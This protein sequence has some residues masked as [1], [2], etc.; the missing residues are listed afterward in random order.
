LWLHSLK[1]AQLLRSA[2]CLH[3]NQSRSYL[4]HLVYY[5][6]L[7]I[8]LYH[9]YHIIYYIILYIINPLSCDLR[10]FFYIIIFFQ[11]KSTYLL[12][13]RSE[14]GSQQAVSEGSSGNTC[15]LMTLF[16]LIHVF[17]RYPFYTHR[18]SGL[19]RKSLM[20]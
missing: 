3:T 19:T 16:R 6:V 4:N 15:S 12:F 10:C 18:L 2:A 14:A 17:G 8:I 9:I 1:V 11:S 7:Y 20:L 5:I 13:L